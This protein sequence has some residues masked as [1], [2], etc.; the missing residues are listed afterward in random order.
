[1]LSTT[2]K[3]LTQESELV[4]QMRSYLTARKAEGTTGSPKEKQ[5]ALDA[6][7]RMGVVDENGKPKEKI[8]S[9]E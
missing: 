1:M 2:A 9:W 3:Y 7:R 4:L 5:E 8:V 6:L